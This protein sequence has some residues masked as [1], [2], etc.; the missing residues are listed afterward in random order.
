MGKTDVR[1]EAAAFKR[2]LAVSD[3]IYGVGIVSTVYAGLRMTGMS[4]GS[5]VAWMGT[6]LFLAWLLAYVT[7]NILHGRD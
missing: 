2:A 7:R 6:G 4:V 1:P 3:V 5:M